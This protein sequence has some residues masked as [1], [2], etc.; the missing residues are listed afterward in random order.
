MPLDASVHGFGCHTVHSWKR[1]LGG[2][3]TFPDDCLH[4]GGLC[5]L[6]WASQRKLWDFYYD[7]HFCLSIWKTRLNG[8]KWHAQGLKVSGRYQD[9]ILSFSLQRQLFKKPYWYLGLVLPIIS[10]IHGQIQIQLQGSVT[11]ESVANWS[12]RESGPYSAVSDTITKNVTF[13][14]LC[15]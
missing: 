1:T 7:A 14:T 11:L 9:L 10:C 8:V 5:P 13:A 15:Q 2:H 6:I 4:W 12:L 3:I